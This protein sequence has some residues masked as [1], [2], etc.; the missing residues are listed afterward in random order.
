[1]QR[2]PPATG[3]P[4]RCVGQETSAPARYFIL[5]L[6]EYKQR[7]NQWKA[8]SAFQSRN[9]PTDDWSQ[10]HSSHLAMFYTRAKQTFLTPGSEYELNLTSNLLAPFHTPN[11][12]SPH[13]DPA[14]FLDVELE[15]FRTLEESLRR[16]VNAQLN[17]VGNSRVLCGIIAGIV[18]SLA[19]AVPPLVVNFTRGHSR[20]SRLTAVPGLWLG[21]TI[22]LAALHGVCLAV[23][24]FGDLRQLR[25]FELA[26]PPIS[27]PK[28]LPAFKPNS[29]IPATRPL[30]FA[31][32]ST[33]PMQ[34]RPGTGTT[35]GVVVPTPI[36]DIPHPIV[37]TQTSNIASAQG[38]TRSRVTSTTSTRV[39]E[40]S[41]RTES[42]DDRIHISPA[43]YDE[44]DDDDNDECLYYSAPEE[45]GGASATTAGAA[46]AAAIT[47]D[48]G[49]LKE[50]AFSATA[51]FIRPFE[52]MTDDEYELDRSLAMPAKHQ[53]MT[54]F[55]F[56]A[57]PSRPYFPDSDDDDDIHTHPHTRSATSSS[58]TNTIPT[59]IPSPSSP[60]A[61]ALP[62]SLSHSRPPLPHINT[63]LPPQHTHIAISCPPEPAASP[64][65]IARIQERCNIPKW[66]LQ[67]GYLEPSSPASV[68]SSSRWTS[69]GAG[70]GMGAGRGTGTGTGGSPLPH[71]SSPFWTQTHHRANAYSTSSMSMSMSASMSMSLPSPSPLVPKSESDLDPTDEKLTRK[72]KSKS[73]SKEKG[74]GKS[75]GPEKESKVHRR[76]RL[77]N[78]VPAFAVPLTRVLSPVI[79]RGQWEI[80]VRSAVVAFVVAW[81]LVGSLLAV[82]PVGGGR[83]GT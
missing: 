33:L 60:A 76:F 41:A 48:N 10:Q 56:D 12:S 45:K 57:L 16:F 47:P 32:P 2:D 29:F 27:K 69:R 40:E 49:G 70:R 81:V 4:R 9:A 75:R 54:S 3:A 61:A 11:P 13:P 65:F 1:M 26:R 24:I 72:S 25:K 68:S 22:V 6:R 58:T 73:K 66:R 36:T 7:Y 5:W 38:H 67:T 39:S 46:G 20:W 62:P 74:K 59:P 78:A 77:M 82:P 53:V 18:F 63:F 43:Y 51:A 42:T 79:V 50:G 14:L 28:P 15:T 35:P 37:G 83:G 21:L 17:N 30:S 71:S 34:Q 19:G 44:E 52:P 55:N 23:Y 8:Q 64:S 31:D 80:V